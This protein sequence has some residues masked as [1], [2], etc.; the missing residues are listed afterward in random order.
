M[1]GNEEHFAQAM[2]QGH[3]AAWDQQWEQ[4]ANHYRQALVEFPEDVK[5][6]N[7]LGLALLELGE[8]HDALK[9]YIRAAELSPKDPTP[10]LKIAEILENFGQHSKAVKYYMRVAELYANNRNFEKAIENWSKVIRIDPDNLPAHSRLA[11]VNERLNRKPQAVIEYITIASLMQQIGEVEKAIAATNHALQIY[12]QGIEAHQ[13]LKLL[14]KG[15]RLPQPKRPP[16]MTGPLPPVV[17]SKRGPDE[18]PETIQTGADPVE[19]TYHRAISSLAELIFEPTGTRQSSQARYGIQS[20]IKGD[21]NDD[22]EPIDSTKITL[23]INQAIDSQSRN[24]FVQATKELERAI[25]AGLDSPAASFTLGYLLFK[26]NRLESAGRTLP[27]ALKHEGYALGSRL[28]L[29]QIQMKMAHVNEASTHFLEA[30]KIADSHIVAPE[31]SALLAG[32]YDPII[33]ANTLETDQ[34]KQERLCNNVMELLMRPDWSEHLSKTREQLPDQTDLDTPTPLAEIIVEA[35]SNQVVEMFTSIKQLA[36]SGKF[37]T[38][39]EEA[40]YALQYAPTYLPLHIFIGEL[41]LQ[42][43]RT[44]EALEKFIIVAKCYNMRGEASR[45]I[46]ILNK[47]ISLSPMDVQARNLIIEAHVT[48][49]EVDDAV[50]EFINLAEVYY[51][52]ADLKLALQTYIRSYQYLQQTHVDPSHKIEIL[53]RIADIYLQ[54]LDW[55]Q[56]LMVFEQVRTL[57][58]DDREILEKIIELNLRLNQETQAIT[59]IDAYLTLLI[60]SG[61]QDT[62]ITF[63]E[64]VVEEYSNNL[65]IRGRIAD[66]YRKVGRPG[67]AVRHLDQLGELLIETGDMENAIKTIQTIIAM[68]PPNVNDYQKL[69]NEINPH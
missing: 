59:E 41:L 23:H 53:G 29:G 56:A 9:S 1:T 66:L 54:S 13:A 7:S 61:Q 20:L 15:H 16:G 19:S 38:A 21:S 31:K 67:D 42:E 34:R 5:A 6:L 52:L 49:G 14:R 33:E 51:N 43:N 32:L 44:Q 2:K 68:N 28:L 36:R 26:E 10:N 40:F 22:Q 35:E 63:L 8:L 60:K 4:A 69:L 48:R 17:T 11:L 65:K 24:E 18:S 47:V 37:Q 46:S 3:S 12:P 45:G 27:R 58:P 62:A 39:M 50:R 55:R 57:T 25:Q 64:E 30:L